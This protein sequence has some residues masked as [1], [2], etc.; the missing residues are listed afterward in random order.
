MHIMP[1]QKSGKRIN[2]FDHLSFRNLTYFG[3]ISTE[4]F[5]R[6]SNSS[7]SNENFGAQI[8]SDEL[9]GDEIFWKFKG[10]VIYSEDQ[11]I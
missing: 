7:F 8:N 4:I 10:M 5:R 2:F 3:R 11:M 1:Y 9:I 6:R